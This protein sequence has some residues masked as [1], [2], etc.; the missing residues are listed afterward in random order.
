MSA[1]NKTS[2][3]SIASQ[4]PN[5]KQFAS[6]RIQEFNGLFDRG[7]F[8]LVHIFD[9]DGYRVY[10]GRSVDSIRNGGTAHAFPKSRFVVMAFNDEKFGLLTGAPTVQRSSQHLLLALFATP[11]DLSLVTWDILQAYTQAIS[12]I[13]RPIFIRAPSMLNVHSNLLV[14]VDR[15]LYRLPESGFH[16][17][18]T[19][20]NH[21]KTYPSMTAAVQDPC[22]LFTPGC[23]SI[24]CKTSSVP[25]GI[26]A[27]QT[28]DTLHFGNSA[29][30]AKKEKFSLKFPSKPRINLVDGHCIKFNGGTI[31]PNN[32]IVKLH[33]TDHVKTL[34]KIETNNLNQSSY[35]SQRARRAYIASKSSLNLTF[36]FAVSSQVTTANIEVAKRLNKFIDTT[37]KTNN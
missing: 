35:I 37:K 16:W 30:L 26:H 17:F 36:A 27:L 5:N 3:R 21:H 11:I 6:S 7:V 29:F 31:P 14:C 10:N 34:Q 18:V 13:T 8:S 25:R 33:Q 9:A 15:P 19:Y 32:A 22:F 12:A 28:D 23:Q 2:W 24:Y 4:S 20:R 1:N